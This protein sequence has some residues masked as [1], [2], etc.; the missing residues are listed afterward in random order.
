MLFQPRVK[1]M[2]RKNFIFLLAVCF[3]NSPAPSPAQ[4]ASLSSCQVV[5]TK[6][7]RLLVD[8]SEKALLRQCVASATCTTFVDPP[9]GLND[10]PSGDIIHG[11]G[12]NNDVGGIIRDPLKG[13]GCIFGC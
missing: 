11:I 7:A 12:P 4:Q 13:I 8:E 5:C 10:G 9:N 6:A 3:V 1:Q 2:L